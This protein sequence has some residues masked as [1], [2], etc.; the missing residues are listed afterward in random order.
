MRESGEV[1]VEHCPGDGVAWIEVP[2]FTA[3]LKYAEA[4]LPEGLV[5]FYRDAPK[6]VRH[7]ATG[8]GSRE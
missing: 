1:L 5:A 6:S 3:E 8:A 4:L 7:G 2:P